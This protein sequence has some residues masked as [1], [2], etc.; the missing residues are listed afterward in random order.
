MKL[1]KSL[2]DI[3]LE[4]Y[5][6]IVPL[7]KDTDIDKWI[8]IIAILSGKSNTE[9]EDIDTG[10]F[11]QYRSQLQFLLEPSGQLVKKHVWINGSLYRGTNN[12]DKL[13][14]SQYVAIKTFLNDGN[15]YEQLHNLA[16]CCYKKLTWKGWK[17]IGEDHVKLS[18]AFLKKPVYDVMPLVFFCSK[19]LS[20][21]M[22]S[23]EVY[24][25][26]LTLIK[27]RMAEVQKAISEG[28]FSPV[29]V[30]TLQ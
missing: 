22:V 4:E 1:P 20:N 26:S 11:K 15:P 24:L 3:T 8:S 2:K 12:A 25:Q 6:G 23:T 29:G 30:G 5:Q 21:S 27:K 9:I 18:N 7:L 19:V 28:S 13:N 17:Y 16:P 14:T 10:V